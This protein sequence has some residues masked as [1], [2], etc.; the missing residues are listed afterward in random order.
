MKAGKASGPDSIPS[1]LCR[2]FPG[3]IAKQIYTLMMK[4]AIQGHEPL[5]LKGGTA[6]PIWKG[7]KQKDVCS[8]FRSILLSSNI[9]K[10]FIRQ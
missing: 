3:P 2:S 10:P 5:A 7:K 4:T 8:A 9:R 6:L 1:E